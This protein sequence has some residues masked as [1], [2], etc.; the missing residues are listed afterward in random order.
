MT[1]TILAILL[2]SFLL[3]CNSKSA[4]TKTTINDT[5]RIAGLWVDFET[6]SVKVG[7]VWMV[8][9]DTFIFKPSKD[10]SVL[11]RVW[12]TDTLFF[13]PRIEKDSTGK[14]ILIG[15]LAAFQSVSIER[16]ADSAQNKLYRWIVEHP[17][18]FNQPKK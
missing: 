6:K 14:E 12:V 16:N 2:F 3:S 10:T 9:K 4:T 7:L 1:K 13:T 5:T 11:N 8:V 15:V 17:Q 18:Y